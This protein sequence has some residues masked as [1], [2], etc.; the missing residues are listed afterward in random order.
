MVLTESG[1]VKYRVP[2]PPPCDSLFALT[3]C[4]MQLP[5]IQHL[6]A[7]E[8]RIQQSL[9]SWDTGELDILGFGEITTVFRIPTA[10]GALA[11]KRFPVFREAADAEAHI[12][13]IR[14][15]VEALTAKGLRVVESDFAS[16]PLE[17]GRLVLYLIQPMLD[18][19]RIGPE[20]FRSLP[21]GE[22]ISRFREIL[23][24]LKAVV[25]D[26][27][28]P[29]GQLSNWAFLDEGLTYL[30]VSTPFMRGEDGRELCDWETLSQSVLNGLLRP[31]RGYYFSKIPET[32]AFYYDLRG[33]ALDFLG[34][35]RK[36]GLDHFIEPFVPVANETLELDEPIS[37][38][39][40]KQYYNG[41]ADFYAI[42]M[43]LFRAN[44]AFHRLVLRRTYPNFI[45][46][47]IER[48]KFQE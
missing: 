18:G 4:F 44:R 26:R 22:A 45:P 43:A 48:N 33:Q 36:E 2:G 42:L 3:G 39:D 28:A 12:A 6:E 11:C 41:N 7:L 16:V 5:P 47:K 30:D 10:D 46:P 35:L 31:L 14:R 40:V 8:A 1:S 17:K 24:R 21:P 27:L 25:S 9:R 23:V 20:Y 15:Y 34:N 37:F 38:D 13:L 19:S 29:D 32:V